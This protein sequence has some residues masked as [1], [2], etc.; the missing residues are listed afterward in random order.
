[1]DDRRAAG[2]MSVYVLVCSPARAFIW[3]TIGTFV[4]FCSFLDIATEVFSR[5]V[6]NI[7]VYYVRSTK[8]VNCTVL[9]SGRL[10]VP[11]AWLHSGA[12]TTH[13]AL[14]A[15]INTNASDS[16][17]VQVLSDVIEQTNLEIERAEDATALAMYL[18]K[19]SVRTSD[20]A[21]RRPVATL[22]AVAFF[23]LRVL[24]P[25]N[26]LG[27]VTGLQ[28]TVPSGLNQVAVLESGAIVYTAASGTRVYNSAA[29]QEY[30]NIMYKSNADNLDL[31]LSYFCADVCG[32]D[33]AAIPLYGK[34]LMET[35]YECV[36]QKDPIGTLCT[37]FIPVTLVLS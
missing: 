12:F 1:M 26:R 36:I 5:V 33:A 32:Y 29:M 6:E 19:Q 30:T 17:V 23:M 14:A 15:T 8:D 4:S 3:N 24:P 16:A 37:C 22:F 13:A 28:R 25:G 9:D 18:Q 21:E 11:P 20:V 34:K 7:T 35:V 2:N 10:F 27:L 31:S